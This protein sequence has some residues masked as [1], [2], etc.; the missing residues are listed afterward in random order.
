MGSEQDMVDLQQSDAGEAALPGELLGHMFGSLNLRELGSAAGVCW[1]W[2]HSGIA[3]AGPLW[4]SQ[5]ERLGYL[6]GWSEQAAAARSIRCGGWKAYVQRELELEKRWCAPAGMALRARV[7]AA[8]HKHWVP[9]ILMDPPSRELVT[10]SYDGTVRFWSHA[11]AARPGC[12]KVLTAGPT[13]GFSCIGT[14]SQPRGS[15]MLAAGSEL[16]HVHV[17]EVNS[18][19]LP[20]PAVPALQSSLLPCLYSWLCCS[21]ARMALPHLSIMAG[22]A[23]GGCRRRQGGTEADLR[24]R[25]RSCVRAAGNFH[26]SA[27]AAGGSYLDSVCQCAWHRISPRSPAYAA[28][29]RRRLRNAG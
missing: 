28:S 14:L 2:R 26:Y 4:K 29:S 16:G 21:V 13:E 1:R 19:F 3:M 10:C 17:W 25:G 22:L 9:S 7:L 6:W 15:V 18:A 24:V 8:G 20:R 5:A 27:Y 11:D 12:F 23:A